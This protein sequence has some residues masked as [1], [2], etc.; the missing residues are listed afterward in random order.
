MWVSVCVHGWVA[1]ECPEDLSLSILVRKPH[2][3]LCLRKSMRLEEKNEGY[4]LVWSRWGSESGVR[5]QGS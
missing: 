4:Q 1:K 3:E 2:K 5:L